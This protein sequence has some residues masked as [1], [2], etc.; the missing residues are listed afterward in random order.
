MKRIIN[1]L[2]L[3]FIV[4]LFLVSVYSKPS[5]SYDVMEKTSYT[6]INEVRSLEVGKL[7]FT[8]ISFKDYSS[9]STQA[10]GLSGVVT[11]NYNIDIGYFSTVLYYDSNYNKIAQET[12]TTVAK[13]GSN[14]YNHMSNL[15]ILNGHSVDEIKYYQLVIFI[16]DVNN[17]V[18][19]NNAKQTPSKEQRYKSNDYVIDKYD[20]NIIVNE[21]NTFDI[22]ETITAYFNVSKH[23]IFRTIPLKNTVT[24]LDGT[25]STNRAQVSNVS[26]DKNY[27]TTRENGNYVIKI[28][29]A[30][31]TLFGTQTYVIK[32][33]YNIGKDP[34]KDYDE[35]YYN[36]IGNEWDTVIGNVT[37]TIT[38]P[39][40]FDSSKLGFSSGPKGSTDNS[41]VIYNVDGNKITGSY[42]G[43]LN[44]GEALTVRCELPEGYFVGAK[45]TYTPLVYT[46]F[47]IP[48]L[49][50]IISFVLWFLFG[51]DDRV[52]ETVEFYPPKGFNSLEVGFL[53][54]GRADEK[55]VTSLLIYLANKGYI[56]ITE[57][58][59]Y[60]L[61][62]EVFTITK[63]KEYDGNNN[64]ER[65]FLEGLFS[66]KR[67]EK[68]DY[69]KVEDLKKQAMIEGEKISFSEATYRY[70]QLINKNTYNYAYSVSSKDLIDNFYIT[71]NKI[72]SNVNNKKNK[73][74]ILEKGASGN[75]I[76]IFLLICIT[77]LSMFGIP[78]LEYAG[79]KK[80][81]MIMITCLV[82]IYSF[83]TVLVTK[84]VEL[85]SYGFFIVFSIFLFNPLPIIS[86]ITSE[87]IYLLGFITSIFCLIGMSLFLK[88]MPKRTKK[89]NE[90]LGKLRG[91]K[92]FL[93]VAEKEKLE[94]LVMQ[95]PTYFYDILPYTY[96][97]G[98][99]D[100]W[101]K[102][103]EILSIQPPSWYSSYR[104][105]DV[106]SFGSF[107]NS[108]M[109]S[110]QSDMTYS[111]VNT[112]SDSLSG[113]GSSS[114]GSSSGGSSSGGGS[115]G[116]G[117]GGGGGG[118]W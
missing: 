20:I 4:I 96:V 113:G 34:A 43:I 55:D 62:S 38:M 111:S 9:T 105:F 19:S 60:S 12:C 59:V 10:L 73:N 7:S 80:F 46:M 67:L 101:I 106:N 33:R 104:N 11:N 86:T 69:E 71:L 47:S 32:Y 23:G 15:K 94:A 117:S 53:Y 112:L 27:T 52:V 74:K 42:N 114:G 108:T 82:S 36:I 6:S 3:L 92:N 99:S 41:K 54:K 83:T 70:H 102:K 95:N 115:S 84:R 40:E 79:T 118:S 51:R 116:G 2:F 30:N 97:L 81:V 16:P 68:D 50:L 18:L 63:L 61:A 109:Y 44:R 29:D 39:K 24:R 76:I 37:F 57:R 5:Y 78:M 35:L 45:Y 89:G 48:I 26:V 49:G 14:S 1:R 22:T 107:F 87:I 88:I 110:A 13:K 17:Q 58:K 8:D 98:V 93:E 91:F 66:K 75:K 21:N 65:I 31:R 25:T 77:I 85:A 90:I 103:F 28:G 56:K 64:N 100:K 72:L